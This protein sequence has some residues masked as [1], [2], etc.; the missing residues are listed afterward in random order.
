[1]DINLLIIEDEMINRKTLA[2]MIQ[3]QFKCKMF[4]A[5]TGDEGLRIIKEHAIHIVLV[6]IHLQETSGFEIVNTIKKISPLIQIIFITGLVSSEHIIQ[7]IRLG[8]LDFISKPVDF[9]QLLLTLNRARYNVLKN[10]HIPSTTILIAEDEE[11]ARVNLAE[12]IR[13]DGY[14]VFEAENGLQAIDVFSENKI[15]IALLDVKMPKMTGSEAL[16]KM[17]SFSDDFEAIIIT[18]FSDTESAM[19][20]LR[21]GAFYYVKKP[22]DLDSL[23]L[24]IEKAEEKLR[25][26]RSLLYRN[27]ENELMAKVIRKL[28]DDDQYTIKLNDSSRDFFQQYIDMIP[29]SMILVDQSYHI[30]YSNK[31]FQTFFSNSSDMID[32]AFISSLQKYHIKTKLEDLKKIID[33]VLSDEPGKTYVDHK[34]SDFVLTHVK[35]QLNQNEKDLVIMLIHSRI[36]NI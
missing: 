21:A 16:V 10:F 8:A 20:A 28:S 2:K 7:A 36:D 35:A 34:Y 9:D 11:L 30:D 23:F 19:Q 14:E 12:V 3:D 33:K 24:L 5:E 27:R 17:K 4:E 26:K 25:L 6:D 18:G 31:L 1:M 32:D 13:D 15:D 29:I 22:I